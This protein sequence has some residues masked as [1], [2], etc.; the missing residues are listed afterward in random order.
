M[1]NEGP[2]AVGVAP[3][4]RNDAASAAAGGE[5]ARRVF[6]V[7]V[8]LG[9]FEL[10]AV[11]V[12]LLV[13]LLDLGGLDN[14]TWALRTAL[15]LVIVGP[16]LVVL[17]GLARQRDRAAR[18]A[19]G[20]L[21]W[22]VVSALLS[23]DPLHALI[24]GYGTDRG[25]LFLAGFMAC[26][27]VGRRVDRTVV[28]LLVGATVFA[29]LANV[30]LGF[31]QVRYG[32]LLGVLATND[33][34]AAGFTASSV[35]FGGLMAG[36]MALAGHLAAHAPRAR[37]ARQG[38]MLAT[39]AFC[40]FGASL[41]GSRIALVGGA[42]A[43]LAAGWRIDWRRVALVG[44]AVATGIGLSLLVSQASS[45]VNRIQG[46]A[47]SGVTPRVE[48]W[49]AA[50]HAF[51]ERPVTG[52]G[53]GQFRTA[54]SP[55]LTVAYAVHEGADKLFFDAHD[56]LVEQAT[57]V[58][59]VGLVLLGGWLVLAGRGAGPMWW[60]AVGIAVTWLLEPVSIA[61][62]PVAF[63][64]LGAAAPSLPRRSQPSAAVV[65]AVVILTALGLVAGSV[66]VYASHEVSIGTKRLGSISAIERAQRVFPPDPTLADLRTQLLVQRARFAP[67][68]RNTAAALAAARGVAAMD[69]DRPTW[70]SDLGIYELWWGTPTESLA[71]FAHAL[72]RNPWSE[73]ALA[74]QRTAAIAAHDRGLATEANRK[75]CAIR[76]IA[77]R[78]S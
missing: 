60:L 2:A 38:V 48:M 53:P 31:C 19:L 28:P 54:T 18:W 47:G 52:W 64:A 25:V 8:E 17:G 21:V 16:G 4:I 10:V 24:G 32:K 3:N 72:R 67:T 66:V 13:P 42:I 34:R 30:G 23:R 37:S 41:S 12:V 74:G 51:V 65:S 1:V 45:T 33:G 14:A 22:A 59:I 70:W 43:A 75:L 9:L 46:D 55:R 20:F 7:S 76:S 29:A 63:L 68:R 61:T 36:G 73:A 5:P 50:G 58:G 39:V 77:C 71:A 11:G 69:P 57:T 40:G 44:L 6:G 15:L 56:V 26:W 35:Y 78:R 27:A 62:A 49:R